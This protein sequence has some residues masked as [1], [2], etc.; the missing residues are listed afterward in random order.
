MLQRGTIRSVRM[1]TAV[2]T[3]ANRGIGLALAV[4]Y[5][6]G[7]DAHVIAVVRDRS[8]SA[9]LQTLT[10]TCHGRVRIVHA[11]VAQASSIAHFARELRAVPIDLL[12]NNAGVAGRNEFGCI[13]ARDLES[14]FAVNVF[15]PLLLTQALRPQLVHGGKVVNITSPLGSLSTAGERTDALIYSMSK[16]A[17]NMLSAKL[18]A[19]LQPYGVAV[20]ALQPGGVRTRLGGATA[21]LDADVSA[22]AMLRVIDSFRLADSG[23]FLDYDGRAS[24]A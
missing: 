4:H 3:G 23:A 8:I 14:L 10:Q 18:A 21:P 15:A 16:A 20:L 13:T 2:I 19:I 9:E 12:I 5:A 11:D 22:T 17:L 6:R 1:P 24:V 7:A